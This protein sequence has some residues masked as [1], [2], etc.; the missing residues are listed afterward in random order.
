MHVFISW[1]GELSRQLAQAIHLWLKDTLQFVRPFFTPD[2]IGKG[3]K[4]ATEISK[5]LAN[6]KVCII[7]LT[8]DNLNSPWI[9]FEAGAISRSVDDF[10]LVCPILFDL[11]TTD[12]LEPLAQFQATKF[13][14]DEIFRLLTT[15]NSNAGE[16]TLPSA[17]LQRVFDK[18]WPDLES[19]VQRILA[20]ASSAPSVEVRDKRS[21][22][23]ETLA[24]VRDIAQ[25]LV[26]IRAGTFRGRELTN[27]S[28][29]ISILK[30]SAVGG[31]LG[32]K[33]GGGSIADVFRDQGLPW[34]AKSNLPW[35]SGSAGRDDPT[36]K[37]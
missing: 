29:V 22:L 2:D 19:E 12:V 1:S 8:R 23:E 18:W 4:W 15:I 6:S 36:K 25:Q 27:L 10:S 11:E 24:L 33:T 13:S 28:E 20:A 32:E 30:S 5:Q 35:D 37:E 17:N 16:Q 34:Q 21:L 31:K 7:V 14:K 9:M 26:E 3:R